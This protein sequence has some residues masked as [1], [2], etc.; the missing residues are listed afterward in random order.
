MA[1]VAPTTAS[2]EW[3][4]LMHDAARTSNNPGMPASFQPP[5]VLRWLTPRSPLSPFRANAGPIGISGRIYQPVSSGGLD[6]FNASNGFLMATAVQSATPVS[7]SAPRASAAALPDRIAWSPGVGLSAVSP[8]FGASTPLAFSNR[9]PAGVASSRDASPIAVAGF[10]ISGDRAGNVFALTKEGAVAW[11][12]T[13]DGEVGPPCAAEGLG[14]VYILSEGGRLYAVDLFSGDLRWSF[15]VGAGFVT[16]YPP[17]T[18]GVR[19]YLT[20]AIEGLLYALDAQTGELLWTV[21]ATGSNFHWGGTPALADGKVVWGMI[22]DIAALNA[23]TGATIWSSP[24]DTFSEYPVIG[25]GHV[26]L[27]GE[28]SLEVRGLATGGGARTKFVPRTAATVAPAL[29]PDAGGTFVAWDSVTL[30]GFAN[31]ALPLAPAKV[32]IEP[33]EFSI[34]V[35]WDVPPPA[36]VDPPPRWYVVCRQGDYGTTV[37]P[38]G[39]P[40]SSQVA[41][42]DL[43]TGVLRL[44]PPGATTMALATGEVLIRLPDN[45]THPPSMVASTL[46]AT[47]APLELEDTSCSP[48]VGYTYEVVNVD[49]AGT[50]SPSFLADGVGVT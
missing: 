8:G 40:Q 39:S 11:T 4:M 15:L 28:G 45:R 27:V 24:T 25:N 1:A 14:L 16:D 43:T 31:E 23:A 26:F 17:S 2:P 34:V 21:A 50:A 10:F 12:F 13:A 6:Q 33:R 42:I 47:V 18:D 9:G 22:E 19:V 3:P 20:S 48:N 36:A 32:E 41:A 37:L 5:F 7:G 46:S 35:R 30:L 44:A 38:P 29:L 49:E